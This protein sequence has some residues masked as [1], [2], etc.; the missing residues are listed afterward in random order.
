MNRERS[1]EE[2]QPGK[3]QAGEGNEVESGQGLGQPLVVASQS[4]EA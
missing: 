2:E 3:Q 4:A 1:E